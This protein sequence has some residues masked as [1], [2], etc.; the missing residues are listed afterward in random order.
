MCFHWQ[1]NCVFGFRYE[2]FRF[3]DHLMLAIEFSGRFGQEP[4]TTE[5]SAYLRHGL[6]VCGSR[7]RKWGRGREGTECT[8][9]RWGAYIL[10]SLS[11]LRQNEELTHPIQDLIDF[12]KASSRQKHLQVQYRIPRS[13]RNLT[14]ILG[15][16]WF[17]PWYSILD[18][19]DSAK[20]SETLLVPL[21]R[22]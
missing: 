8:Q 18:K 7:D 14:P 19:E 21:I 3:C 17:N 15:A 11:L 2:P 10:Y 20:E 22:Q 4:M 9:E 1:I 13:E 12:I 5:C 6:S 16:K